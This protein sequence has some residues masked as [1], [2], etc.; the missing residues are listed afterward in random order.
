M[1]MQT[2]RRLF[3]TCLALACLVVVAPLLSA[4]I[5]PAQEAEEGLALAR[6]WCTSCHI[7]EPGAAG[8]DAARPFAAIA[9]D[10][11]FTEQ[12]LRAWLADPHPPMPNLN[13]TRAE[14]AAVTAYLRS[15]RRA[16]E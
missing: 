6:Q 7:V 3:L 4:G 1:I 8:S 2:T 15:L 11:S 5:A 14:T 9:N 16:A 10:A 13:L 12:G